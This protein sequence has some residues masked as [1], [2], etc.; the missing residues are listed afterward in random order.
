MTILPYPILIISYNDDTR[1]ALAAALTSHNV[2]SISCSNFCEAEHLARHTLFN[3]IL[4][5]LPTIIKSK[6]EEKV[7]AYTLAN[8]FPTLRVRAVGSALVPMSM[9]GSSKQDKSLNDFLNKTC[10]SF[11]P[12]K[13]RAYRR[14]QFCMSTIL[15]YNGEEFRSFTQDLSWGGAFLVDVFTEKFSTETEA[16]ISFTELGFDLN[17]TIHWIKPWGQRQTPGIGVS[18]NK[19]DDSVEAALA[20]L[21]RSRKD[22]D[23]DRMVI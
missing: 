19:L 14:H 16:V 13:L 7:V 23:R 8:C 3:G 12:R 11:D 22:F 17:T 4:V 18:F 15:R 10:T 6:G 1:S 21:F 20:N 9:P 2:A 5:D